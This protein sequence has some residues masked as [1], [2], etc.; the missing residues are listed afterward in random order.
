MAKTTELVSVSIAELIPYENNAKQ[1]P[2]DQ[3]EK[4]KRSIQEFGFVSPCI[5]DREMNIIAGHGRV[6]AAKALGMETVPCVFVEGL[7][8][9]QRKAYILA[10]N[11]LTELGGWD[12]DLVGIELRELATAG[13]DIDLT[14][15]EIDD[16]QIQDIEDIDLDGEEEEPEPGLP[17]IAKYGDV[18]QL[19]DHRLMCGDSTNPADVDRLMAG[20][21]ADLLE[22]DPPYN[23]D[24]EG[25]EGKIENDNMERSEFYQFLL[26]AFQN[27]YNAMRPGAVFYIWHPDSGGLDFRSAAESSGLP[28]RQNVIWVKSSFT[29]G[30]QDYQWRHEPCLYGWKEGAAHYFIDLRTLGTA[31]EYDRLEEMDRDELIEAYRGLLDSISTIAHERKPSRSQLH[32]TMKPLSLIKKQIRNSSQEGDLVLDLF[33]GS[34]TTLVAC[35][36]MGRTCYMMEY[37]PHFCDVTIRRWEEQ[38]GQKAVRV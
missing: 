32:P 38:T 20:R 19:G 23:V 36:E 7:T 24:Y 9:E 25:A 18:W 35:E 12:M 37:D 28:I 14:G 15:F 30:R 31:N 22:T 10:D 34:G 13:F 8:E 26:A 21:K 33:G 6:E 29:I 16:V 11:R 4:I 2:K 3:I 27:A 1:H 5:I 17:P